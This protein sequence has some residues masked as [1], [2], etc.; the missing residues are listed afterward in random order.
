MSRLLAVVRREY[1]ERV[2]SK[3]FVIGTVLG[4]VLMAGLMIGPAFLASRQ[5]GKPLKL[6]VLDAGGALGALV[7]AEI[8]RREIAGRKR[9]EVRPSGAGTLEARRAELSQLVVAGTLDGF[10]LLPADALESASAEY[11]GKNVANRIDLRD[12]EK[13][14]EDAFVTERLRGAGLDPERIKALTRRLDLKTSRLTA[15]GAREDRGASFLFSTVMMMM[16]YVTVLMWGQALMTGVIEEKSNRVVEVAV[17]AISP[18]TLLA[19]KLIGVGAAGLSQFLV[20]VV[21]LGLVAAYGGALVP[22]GDLPLPEISAFMLVSFVVFFLLGYFLYA[23][24]Y[25]AIGSAVNTIQEA[26]QLAFP[27]I[28]PLVVSVMFFPAVLQSPDSPLSVGLSLFPFS[29]P[30]LMFLRITVLTPPLWQIGASVAITLLTIVGV[31][32]VSARVYRVGILMYG[33]RPTFP[34]LMKWVRY[35]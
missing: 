15:K 22:S 26:Q 31:T 30:L 32:W 29:A 6:A 19:G 3:A 34:E 18:T 10:V 2:R 21:S 35:R 11:F 9:F 20:W 24:M 25:A 5:L 7:E 27:A 16:L 12:L 17:S 1:L 28:M 4:P 13:A 33:K 14:V 8:A 23:A